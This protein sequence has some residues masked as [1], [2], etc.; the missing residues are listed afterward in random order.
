MLKNFLFTALLLNMI[1]TYLSYKEWKETNQ[2]LPF[3]IMISGAVLF[4]GMIGLTIDLFF[5][6]TAILLH[7]PTLLWLILGLGIVIESFSLYKKLIPGQLI[8]ISLLLFLVM[9][10]IFSIGIYLLIISIILLIITLFIFQRT[11]RIGF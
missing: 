5:N 4:L 9:P 2:T 11:K 10:T 7:T 3:Y 1:G 8:A 6:P